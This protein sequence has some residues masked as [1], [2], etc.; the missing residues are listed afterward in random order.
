M[1]YISKDEQLLI[2]I[3]KYMKKLRILFSTIENLSD[4]EIDDGMDGL[5]LTQCVTNLYELAIRID[6]E[7]IAEKL[8]MLSS[9]RTARLRNISSHDYDAV[10]WSIAKNICKKLL[11]QITPKLLDDC[12]DILA[13]NKSKTKNYTQ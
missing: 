4:A 5:A 8:S 3:T 11:N 7:T 12:A 2:K 9:G 1:S 10:D 6:D 13:A